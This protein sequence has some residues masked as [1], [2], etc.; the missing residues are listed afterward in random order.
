VCFSMPVCGSK[1]L[2]RFL[3]LSA[4]QPRV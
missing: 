1:R 2:V 3:F 4:G